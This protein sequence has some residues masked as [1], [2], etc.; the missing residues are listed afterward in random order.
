MESMNS[1]ADALGLLPELFLLAGAVIALLTGSFTSR[2]RQ[3][4]SRVIA[5]AALTAS[6]VRRWAARGNHDGIH[7]RADG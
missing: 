5:V 7:G 6:A 4:I 3:W 1:G 2:E